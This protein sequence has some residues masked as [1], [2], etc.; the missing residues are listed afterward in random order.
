ML[1]TARRKPMTADEFLAWAQGWAE[2]ERYELDEGEPV[3][4]A[5][6]RARHALAKAEAYV[7]LR[8]AVRGAGVQAQVFPDGMAVVISEYTV[9]EPDAL[10]RLGPP[11]DGDTVKIVDPLIVVEVLS[12]STSA[13][14]TN[15]KLAG[16][17]RV[18]SIHHYLIL[19]PAKRVAT[20]HR[21]GEDGTII[22]R[23]LGDGP[24]RLDPPGIELQSLF[25][26]A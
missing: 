25:A 18:P 5:S 2:G 8:E 15:D 20:H 16:Y 19:N 3:R 1:D 7:R 17:F 24:L 11:V 4:M 9:Y 13:L 22:T 14:D 21:R 10:V 6:E 23:V 12:P 26:P